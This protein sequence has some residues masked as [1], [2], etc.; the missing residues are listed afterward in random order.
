[1]NIKQSITELIG[2]TPLLELNGIVADMGLKAH[3][4]A[5]LEYYNVNMS[6]KDRAALRIIEDAE[7]NGTLRYE[8]TVVETTSGNTGIS[9]AAICAA[10]GYHFLAYMQDGV[11]QERY[12]SIN[13][14]GC[15]TINFSEIE[16][17]KKAMR[18]T[19]GNFM[20]GLNALK[21]ELRDRDDLFY[22]DQCFN[23]S[24]PD[25][26]RDTTGPEIWEDTDGTV[27]II[28]AS[29][30]TGGT[31]SG[32]GQYIKSKNPLVEIVAVEP[33]ED[34]MPH[35]DY[36]HRNVIDGIERISDVHEDEIPGTVD[37]SVID[38]IVS[39]S[40]RDAYEAAR[41]V[42]RKDGVLLG[43]S[44][45]AAIHAAVELAKLKEN[46]GKRIVVIAPDTGLR[47]LSTNLYKETNY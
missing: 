11:T 7:K 5:K 12:R 8:Q 1:M 41:K 34:A 20:A 24:N 14:F 44:S 16:S 35:P 13:A 46:F 40:A 31:I 3:I 2:H 19:G 17:V 42:A 15:E 22:T 6:S 27:D 26:H 29:V 47:Y 25:V 33:D 43:S 21:E 18:E 45:G 10:K 32:I 38:R 37:F 23:T 28:V 9:L 4:I 30:G 39:V 36:P